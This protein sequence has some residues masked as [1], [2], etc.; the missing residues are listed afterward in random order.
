[1]LTDIETGRETE[2]EAI[3]GTVVREGLQEG[4]PTPTNSLL[5]RLVRA[6]TRLHVLLDRETKIAEEREAER[7]LRCS[8]YSVYWLY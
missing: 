2:V 5:L 6:H 1:M 4:V 8:V 7:L 3:Y